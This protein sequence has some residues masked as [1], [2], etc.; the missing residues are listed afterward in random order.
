MSTPARALED[1]PNELW[2]IAQAIAGGRGFQFSADSSVEFENLIQTG[3]DALKYRG[4]AEDGASIAKAKEN[5]ER[6]VDR[7]IQ[8]FIDETIRSGLVIDAGS[9]RILDMNIFEKVLSWFCPCFP[10]C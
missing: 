5:V 4:L 3:A 2:R 6:F 1:L 10:F 7:M 9:T 8:E